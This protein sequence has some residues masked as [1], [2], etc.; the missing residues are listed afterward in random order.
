MAGL[1]RQFQDDALD[2]ATPGD[3]LIAMSSYMFAHYHAVN[4]WAFNR[5]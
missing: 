1:V 4:L 5:R 2:S 3:A